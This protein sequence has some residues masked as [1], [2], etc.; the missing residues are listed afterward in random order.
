MKNVIAWLERFERGVLSVLI[1]SSI[2]MSVIGVFYRYV[3]GQSLS[4]VE[5]VA[6]LMMAA[7]I[8]LG[9]SLAITTKEHIR[10]ELLLQVLPWLRRWLNSLAWLTVLL[11]SAAMAWVSWLFVAKLIDNRQIA[12]SVEWLQIGWP[13]LVVPTGYAFCCI[14]AACILID[15][16]LGR[17]KPPVTELDELLAQKEAGGVQ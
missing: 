1:A 17:A 13:M 3:L 14:K 9:A 4:F 8:V 10:V 5:E 2:L 15:E 16:V 6:G 11:V 12:S 7:I